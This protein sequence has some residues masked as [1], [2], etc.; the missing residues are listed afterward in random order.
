HHEGRTAAWC[1]L[2]RDRPAV[3]L[4]RLPHQRQSQSGSPG[5]ASEVR[6]EDP[7]RVLRRHAKAMITHGHAGASVVQRG[8]DLDL[9]VAVAG[10][11]G[12]PQDVAEGPAQRIVVAE[13]DGRRGV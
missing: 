12:I 13:E 3:Q 11:D 10:L 9:A 2:D 4:Y 8:R 1:G 7:L 6:L 5:L